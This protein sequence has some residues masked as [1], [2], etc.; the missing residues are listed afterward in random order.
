MGITEAN[1]WKLHRYLKAHPNQYN[2]IER[3]AT[4]LKI[5]ATQV[6]AALLWV[7]DNCRGLGW[8]I[9]RVERGPGG[10]RYHVV[11][12]FGAAEIRELLDG[13]NY[14]ATHVRNAMQRRSLQAELCVDNCR[15]P[16]SRGHTRALAV[17]Q[18]IDDADYELWKV[19][20]T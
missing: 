7:R 6:N 2:T 15:T 1:A 18:L 9:P 20:T 14:E 19:E 17:I 3:L 13:T 4:R 16:G 11:D 10:R 12:T 8:T 5:D